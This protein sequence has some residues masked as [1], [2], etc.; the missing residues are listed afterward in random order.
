MP[1]NASPLQTLEQD[2]QGIVN[3]PTEALLGHP[4]IGNGANGAPGTGGA[5]GAGGLLFGS[6]GAGGAGGAGQGQAGGAGGSAGLIGSGGAGGTGGLGA[7]G[8]TAISEFTSTGPDEVSSAIAAAS[9]AFATTVPPAMI[10]ANRA[11]LTALVS[12]SFLGPNAPSIAV[13][14]ADYAKMWAEA[15]A[16]MSGYHA[17]ASAGTGPL[18]GTKDLPGAVN[19]VLN[20]VSNMLAGVRDGL[21]RDANIFET[22]EPASQQFLDP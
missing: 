3:A 4:L 12:T 19:Q 14:E 17:V 10:A 18:V 21:V 7:L 6:G 2:L 1:S 8:G 11:Q 13:T 22:Q 16:T 15:A 20:N 9:A 5:G